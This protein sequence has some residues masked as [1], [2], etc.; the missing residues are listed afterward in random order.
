M[1][2]S[3]DNDFACS[4]NLSTGVEIV[5]ELCLWLSQ[6]FLC[7]ILFVS[8][9]SFCLICMFHLICSH[10]YR[11][12]VCL[13]RFYH[14]YVLP[15]T[16]LVEGSSLHVT[17]QYGR[18]K[19]L[20]LPVGGGSGWYLRPISCHGVGFSVVFFW[21]VFVFYASFYVHMRYRKKQILVRSFLLS[22]IP[23]L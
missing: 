11:M 8:V 13:E 14:Y 2:K 7:I 6:L 22:S 17:W 21:T 1:S 18:P 16:C 12:T 19:M 10:L 15:A 3:I 4:R 20:G 23:K 5:D 9:S